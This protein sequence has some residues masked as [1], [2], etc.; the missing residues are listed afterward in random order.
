MSLSREDCWRVC[1]TYFAIL[2]STGFEKE[3]LPAYCELI[4]TKITITT[5]VTTKVSGIRAE[6]ED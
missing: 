5:I 4:S 1:L 2:I 3:N 6:L